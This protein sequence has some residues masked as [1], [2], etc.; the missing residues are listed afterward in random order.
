MDKLLEKLK[1][2]WNRVLE[3]WNRFTT[4]QKTLI[5]VAGAAVILAIVVIVTML[6]RPQYVLLRQCETTAEAAEVRDLLD[7]EGLTY[8]ISN[9]G[10]SIKILSSQQ[11]DANL[12]LGANNIQAAGYG[13]ENVTDGGLSTTESD[14]QKKYVVY[15]QKYLANDVIKKFSAVKGAE[16]TLNIPENDGT[17][18]ASEEESSAWVLLELKDEFTADSAAYLAR[19][20][21][22][23][24]GNETTNNIVIMDTE[25]NML[26]TGEDNYSVSGTANA[27]LSVKSEAEK[28]VKNE[29]RRVLLG[30][31]EFDNVEVAS[32]LV[33]DFSTTD[34]TTHTYTPADGQTQGVLSHED[35]YSSE[36]TSGTGGVPGTDSNNSDQTTYVMPDNGESSSTV[37]E[38]SRDYLPNEEIT[39]TSTPAGLIDYTQSSLAA[40]LIS[41]NV[42]REEDVR[43]QGL[44]AGVT[45]DEYKLANTARTRID[46]DPDLYVAVAN[47]TGIPQDSISLV[48]YSENVFFDAEGSSITATDI[49]QIVLIVVILALL[50]F[51]VL[52]SMR[53]EKHEEEE[54]ELSVE[55]LLQS[56]PETQLEDISL[57]NESEEKRLVNKFV[58]ENPEAAANLLRNWLNEDWG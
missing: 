11:S 29:V 17:L 42:V 34:R 41:Y 23:A 19:A 15:M 12:L 33:L 58:E 45:W 52:R 18:I 27:Q 26:F 7:G 20:V 2:I 5:I 49:L 39:T 36:N 25:G 32:N 35:V 13:I 55:N 51:V 50:A 47:A 4:K 8:Q 40:T 37:S 46:V 38:E 53:G 1:E 24:I 56:T 9:D 31:N 48:A 16:V 6:N 3:W 43:T 30:T 22:T 10:L 57:E 21:A 44:L 54:E 14:K 28:Q